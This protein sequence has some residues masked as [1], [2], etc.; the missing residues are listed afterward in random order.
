MAVKIYVQHEGTGRR[1][2]VALM[3]E[4]EGTLT[5]EC[6]TEFGLRHF[7]PNGPDM[8]WYSAPSEW[9]TADDALNAAEIHL[10]HEK[11]PHLGDV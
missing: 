9:D 8:D 10:E 2:E 6:Q 4:A 3:D 1:V 11:C 7:V 5:L